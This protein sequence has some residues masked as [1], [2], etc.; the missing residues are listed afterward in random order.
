MLTLFAQAGR[1]LQLKVLQFQ[2]WDCFLPTTIASGTRS[3]PTSRDN[4]LPSL[5]SNFGTPVPKMELCSGS[6]VS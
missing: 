4:L 1:M 5:S 6:I 2:F 3:I